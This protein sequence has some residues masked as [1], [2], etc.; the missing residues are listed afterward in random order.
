MG[1]I[2]WIF[3]PCSP[4]Q[5]GSFQC[6]ISNDRPHVGLGV[7]PLGVLL[8]YGALLLRGFS[9]SSA[10]SWLYVSSQT[11]VSLFMGWEECYLSYTGWSKWYINPIGYEMHHLPSPCNQLVFPLG[12]CRSKRGSTTF[13][14]SSQKP[15]NHA[16]SLSF[17][18]YVLSIATGC[19]ICLL[20]ISCPHSL[21]ISLPI[22]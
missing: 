18:S 3:F 8:L 12:P 22:L 9:L 1:D 16:C 7:W 13:N 11:I 20:N 15:G 19:W 21:S 4:K 10:S 5:S 14:C 17:K 6:D 2:S